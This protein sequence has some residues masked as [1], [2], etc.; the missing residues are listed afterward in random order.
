MRRTLIGSAIIGVLLLGSIGA[1]LAHTAHPVAASGMYS[2]QCIRFH[3]P[4]PEQKAS[5]VDYARCAGP[6]VQAVQSG[7]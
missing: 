3:T 2:A 1:A 5:A 6:F 4:Q 7:Q